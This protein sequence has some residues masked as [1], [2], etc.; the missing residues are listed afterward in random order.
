MYGKK[1]SEESKRK[2]SEAH[3]GIKMPPHAD[4]WKNYMYGKRQTEETKQKIKASHIGKHIHELNYM[5]GKYHSLKT[6]LKISQ[7]NKQIPD[8]IINEIRRLAETKQYTG[9][10]L[11]KKFNISTA[12]VSRI[13]NFK[14]RI[15]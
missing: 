9:K 3:T 7:K 2:M 6:K 12:Q 1:Q 10:E 5:F 4:G 13:I 11:A 14:R 15:L 8:I